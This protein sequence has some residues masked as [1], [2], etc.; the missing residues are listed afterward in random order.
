V[1]VLDGTRKLAEEGFAREWPQKITMSP[2]VVRQVDERWEKLGLPP[3]P[4]RDKVAA[5]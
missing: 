1:L 2:D 4:A 3:L 5:D